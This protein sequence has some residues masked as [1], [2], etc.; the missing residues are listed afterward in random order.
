MYEVNVKIYGVGGCAS[1]L[2]SR[3]RK[4]NKITYEVNV[5]IYGVGGCASILS[6][7]IIKN[8][9]ITYEVNVKKTC[10]KRDDSRLNI[11]YYKECIT[12]VYLKCDM[13]SE[14]M[15]REK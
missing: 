8:N 12:V 11:K 15:N 10:L 5:K 6:S 1:I 14:L 3:I 9:K 13:R 7:R 4:N 2:S